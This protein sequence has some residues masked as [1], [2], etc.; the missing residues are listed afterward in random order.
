MLNLFKKVVKKISGEDEPQKNLV[1]VFEEEKITD[2]LGDKIATHEIGGIWIKV[3][4]ISEF[5]FL[6]TTVV[7]TQ[8]LKTHQ[9]FPING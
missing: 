7:G 8:N 4:E 2:Y 9:Q 3:Q 6:N 5:H 1:E